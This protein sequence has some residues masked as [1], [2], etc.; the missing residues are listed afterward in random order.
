MDDK[1]NK[2]TP[3]QI[4]KSKTKKQR[5]EDVAY[6]MNHAIVCTATD[7]VSPYLGNLIQK[8]FGNKSQLAKWYAAEFIGDFGAIPV[9]VG[10]QRFFPSTMAYISKTIEP[11]FRKSFRRGA[12]RAT[13][14]W[15]KEHG[16]SEGSA[17]YNE[18]F[19]KTYK[20][21][22][23]HIPQALVWA[24][25]STALNVATQLVIDKSKTPISHILAGKIGGATFAAG[26]TLG[27]RILF[28]H[29]AEKFDRFISRNLVLPAD[30]I[31]EK[32]EKLAVHREKT[33]LETDHNKKDDSWKER[34]RMSNT[35]RAT[36]I[37]I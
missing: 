3:A 4:E 19:N 21:E 25:S 24:A 14:E 15:A 13:K 10:I 20:Y 7:I 35:D 6:T 23:S 22:L 12:E 30:E 36:E 29:K 2:K 26:L 28:P 34:I 9:T 1:N 17:E 31:E 37:R 32:I 5:A 33:D 16:V 27:G 18:R 8:K 11:V